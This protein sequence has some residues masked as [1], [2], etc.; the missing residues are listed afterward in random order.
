MK[1]Q[2]EK[3]RKNLKIA[4]DRKTHYAYK[5]KTYREFKVGENAFLKVKAK[6]RSLRLG[7][8]PKLAM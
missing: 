5:N 6:R 1:E 3:I 2:M 8:F 7:S 4:Q